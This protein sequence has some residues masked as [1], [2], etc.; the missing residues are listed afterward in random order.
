MARTNPFQRTAYSPQSANYKPVRDAFS[1]ADFA[2]STFSGHDLQVY[3][4]EIKVGNVEAVSWTI[5]TETVSN[6]V[7]GRRDPVAFTQGKRV[8]VGSMVLQQFARHALLQQ[9]FKLHNKVNGLDI[10]TIGDLWNLSS[11]APTNGVNLANGNVNTANT[12]GSNPL[13]VTSSFSNTDANNLGN[14]SNFRG[15]SA[16]DQ[17]DQLRDQI[18]DAARFVRDTK[19]MYSDQIPPFDIALVGVNKS[20]AAARCLLHGIQITQETG[21]YSQNDMGNSVGMAFVALAV[22]PWTAIETINR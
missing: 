10:G 22:T 9:V 17:Q 6:H 4:N 15:L 5:Q 2:D 1:V 21:G 7:M 18:I 20:G 12:R 14:L 3:F 16:Q 11:G 8:V 13:G 19:V